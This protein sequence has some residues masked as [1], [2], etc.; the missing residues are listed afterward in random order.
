MR[1]FIWRFE[2]IGKRGAELGGAKMKDIVKCGYSS[3]SK[4][5]DRDI[6]SM[7]C[8]YQF[9]YLSSI[10]K[11]GIILRQRCNHAF[12]LEEGIH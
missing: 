8:S 5:A 7:E 4:Y 3:K 2:H 1:E 10:F 12:S 9:L 6:L 11:A